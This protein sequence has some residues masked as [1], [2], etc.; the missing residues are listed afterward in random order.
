M[1]GQGTTLRCQLLSVI[2]YASIIPQTHS[3]HRSQKNNNA[4]MNTETGQMAGASN[5]D[6]G[7]KLTWEEER[8][9]RGKRDLILYEEETTGDERSKIQAGNQPSIFAVDN[10]PGVNSTE[11]ESEFMQE[12]TSEQLFDDHKEQLEDPYT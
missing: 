2:Y 9:V 1:D 10:M 5:D 11:L 12:P 3:R 7:R 4:A 6:Q 8:E